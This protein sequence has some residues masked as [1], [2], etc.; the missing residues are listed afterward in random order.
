MEREKY[1]EWYVDVKS[2]SPNRI[3]DNFLDF[4]DLNAEKLKGKNI[5]SIG[6]WFWIF[7]MDMA[8]N[9]ANVTIV[10]PMFANKQWIDVKLKEN[11]D[12]MKEKSRWKNEGKFEKMKSEIIDVLAESKDE[13]EIAEAQENLQRYNE[14]QAEI[15]EYLR[16]RK[17]LM[18]HLKNWKENQIKYWLVLNSSSWD[19]IKWVD[20]NSQDV[21]LIAHTL[22]HIYNKS[23]WD[24]VNFLSEASKIL[25]SD[26]KFYI[27]DYIRDV[28]DVEK[29]LEKTNLKKYYKVNKWSFVCCFDKEWLDKFLEDEMK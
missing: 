21:V 22:S 26:W 11:M 15:E 29:V 14:R 20:K 8:K 5:T 23:D 10:D 17:I 19:D 16:R 18:E 13:K 12:W 7:E 24:I 27:I 1:P 25:K 6:W 9:W 3:T 2:I 28:P 4:M